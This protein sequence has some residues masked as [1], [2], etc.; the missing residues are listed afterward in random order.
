[1]CVEMVRA[2]MIPFHCLVGRSMH[3]YDDA[4]FKCVVTLCTGF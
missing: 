1:M 4:I 3:L 2:K